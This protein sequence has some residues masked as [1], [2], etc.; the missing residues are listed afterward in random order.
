MEKL[1][2][3]LPS[4]YYNFI[5]KFDSMKKLVLVLVFLGTVLPALPQAQ[6]KNYPGDTIGI[7][8]VINFEEPSP[9]IHINPASQNIW[10]IGEPQKAF[11]NQAYSVPNAVV[12]DTLNYYPVNNASSFDLYVG[13][14]N[15]GGMWGWNYPY[16]IFIDFRHKF[17]TDTLMDGGYITVSWD[18]G[19]TWMNI[20]ND[21]VYF[22]E[23]PNW[24][25]LPFGG[26]PN[27][28]S[29]DNVL[30]NGEPGFSGNSGGW[31]HT[32]MAW[33]V[34]PVK[35]AQDFPPDTMIIRFN[36]IS[37]NV[38]NNKEGW[39][40]DQIRIFSLDLGSGIGENPAGRKRSHMAPNPV[41]SSAV[42]TFDKTYNH[43]EYS[44]TNVTGRICSAGTKEKCSQFTFNRG[45]ISPGIYLLKL[46]IDHQFTETHRI[47]F[48]D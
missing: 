39:M 9:Y 4:I 14:F 2:F 8:T 1:S 7:W 44:L 41:K 38:N 18:K 24:N 12:T 25:F 6:N 30:F 47:I 13:E 36:F 28:Y 23:H 31:V 32:C 29:P 19:L 3:D 26:N 15:M 22:G 5:P 27:L 11:F 21:S 10:Q 48:S 46:I 42:V 43:V 35:S 17:D 40:I 33:F 20:I 16:D 34:W 45:N 37:D